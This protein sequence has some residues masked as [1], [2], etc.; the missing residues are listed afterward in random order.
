MRLTK[1]VQEYE[2]ASKNVHGRVIRRRF[3]FQTRYA[4]ANS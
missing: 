4:F 2:K 1:F 3:L